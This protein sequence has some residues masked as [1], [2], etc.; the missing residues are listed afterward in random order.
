MPILVG[1]LLGFILGISLGL[2]GFFLGRAWEG[3]KVLKALDE[4]KILM[5][6]TEK[7]HDEAH[8]RLIKLLQQDNWK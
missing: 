6:K 7:L 4:V 3:K 2:S 5:D 8:K 1:Y